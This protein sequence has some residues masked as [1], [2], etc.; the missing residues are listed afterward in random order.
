MKSRKDDSFFDIGDS[1]SVRMAQRSVSGEYG[2]SFGDPFGISAAETLVNST[3]PLQPSDL[4]DLPAPPPAAHVRVHARSTLGETMVATPAF[5]ELPLSPEAT[6]EK[7][8]RSPILDGIASFF[9]P[10]S[11]SNNRASG[12]PRSLAFNTTSGPY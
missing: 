4:A 11:G 5:F 2:S 6:P 7:E 12:S 1:I 3:L 8:R 10:L 9:F